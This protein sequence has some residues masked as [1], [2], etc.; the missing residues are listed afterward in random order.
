M[1]L[2]EDEV[3]LGTDHDGIMVLDD[4][5]EP[6]TPLADVL[7]LVEE[8]LEVEPTGN[9]VDLLSVYGIAREVA[10]LFDGEL[11]AARPD[12]ARAR[13]R[14]AG[15]RPGRGS[16]GLPALHR[17]ALPRRRDRRVAGLAEGAA[18]RRR[19]ALDL[20]RRRRDELRDARARQPAARRSTSTRCTAAASSC[21]A[22]RRARSC[23]RST[24]RCAS[25]SRPISLIADADRAVA[26][27]GIMGGEE[28]EV[29]EHDDV[30]AARGGELRAGL[31][32]A[33]AP[34]GSRSAPRARTAGRRASTR[35]SP[36]RPRRSRRGSSSSSPP[37]AGPGDTD[38]QAKLPEPAVI[39]LRPER[40]NAV[41]GL[42]VAAAE[43]ASIL[44]RLGF[45]QSNGGFRV[46]TWRARDV[47]REIDLVEEVAR[48]KMEEIPFTLPEHDAMFGRLTRWQRLRRL[49]EDVLT[50][51]GFSEAYTSSF[52]ADGDAAAAGAAL[53][54]GRGAAHGAARQPRRRGTPQRLGRDSG[55]R[56]LRDRAHVPRRRRAAGRALAR[57]RDRRRRLRGGEVGRRAALRRAEDRAV[58]RARR[59]AASSI[60]ASRRARARGGWASSIPTLLEGTWGAF[61]LDLDALV[62]A[63]PEAV[64]F[65]EVSPYPG[66]AA[67]PR[68]RRR[69]GR[70][71][72]GARSPR[73]AKRRGPSCCAR[74]RRS[75]STAA[76]RSARASARSRSASRSARPSAP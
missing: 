43:Q 72:R 57:R 13:R 47:T 52:V 12:R 28:T 62:A 23:A 37:R 32:A 14:R 74:S 44:V 27:A 21:A 71:G 6:G 49:V 8:V 2:A 38:V 4:A 61:E 58:V 30:G 68:V 42:E 45:E 76:T 40:T 50:G 41:L 15:R 10:A 75:T 7:P 24:A 67:G 16:G 20:E 36:G 17:P 25:S 1:I 46:P 5:L 26:L 18:A 59:R 33:H 55:G 31:A 22:R 60:P 69:R 34:S 29:S 11:V 70:P 9:R 54:G 3:D 56:A 35:T 63:A 39:S 19:R 73:S 64:E 66:G 65:E 53:D 51:C 48:F